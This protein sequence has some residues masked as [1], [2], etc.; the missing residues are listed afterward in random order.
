VISEDSTE[1]SISDDEW[2]ECLEVGEGDADGTA[3]HASSMVLLGTRVADEEK[4]WVLQNSWSCMPI[5][6]MSTRFLAKSGATL[7]FFSPQD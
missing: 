3:F 2:E 4:F 5:I 7:V 1:E 6:D